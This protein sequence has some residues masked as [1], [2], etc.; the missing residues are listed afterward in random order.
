[1]IKR[2]K[3]NLY[4]IFVFIIFLMSLRIT[5]A[6]LD[7]SLLRPIEEFTTNNDELV[8]E[9][10]VICQEPDTVVVSVD[11][12]AGVPDLS[13]VDNPLN[14][15]VVDL[16]SSHSLTAMVLKPVFKD[17]LSLGPRVVNLSFS[18]DG[19]NFTDRGV[20][21]CTSGMGNEY[22]E[23]RVDFDAPINA[24]FVRIDII[25]GWQSGG[26]SIEEV[27]FLDTSERLFKTKTRSI[28]VV[29]R[30]DYEIDSYQASF[31]LTVLLKNG[32]NII[33][34]STKVLE[35]SEEDINEEIIIINANYIPHILVEEDYLILSDGYRAEV[36]IPPDALPSEI[37][38]VSINPLDVDEIIWNSYSDNTYIMRNTFPVMAYEILL[39]AAVPFPVD[40][41]DS[42][43]RQPPNLLVD[44]NYEYPSTWMTTTSALPIWIKI[45][46]RESHTLGRVIIYPRIAGDAA[47]GPKR[48]MILTS[49]DDE[50]YI[51]A[52]VCDDCN[53]SRIEIFLP[54]NPVARY[55]RLEIEEGWQGNNIQINELDFKDGEGA[56]IV[57]YVPLSGVSL[58][59]PVELTILYDD[60]DLTAAGIQ[61][62]ENLA[63]F[64]WNEGMDEWHLVGGRIDEANNWITVNLNHFSTLALFEK[65]ISVPEINWSYNPFSPNGDGIADNTTISISMGEESNGEAK[66]EIFDYTGKLIRTLMHEKSR[67]G[68]MSIVWDGKDE[69]GERVKIGPYIYQ[70]T[71]GK[72][73]RNGVLV[74]AR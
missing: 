72:E 8:I 3:I 64:T 7:L 57:S 27:A 15:L 67:S 70:V 35:P 43:E 26:V 29:L 46:L 59:R 68:Y 69:N 34:V 17:E 58:K 47:Y 48:L 30:I 52:A 40:A 24:R 28:S 31:K 62:E 45:D 42:L 60:K 13:L 38:K 16:G 33:A 23:A 36:S 2:K 54:N 61:R 39:S 4:L 5:Q 32:E 20:F 50:N 11:T 53:T 18:G 1:M 22:G 73:I 10:V 66:V 19:R 44:G 65:A 63:V 55:V 71:V 9:G 56:D 12:P 14:F 21:N 37:N 49:E 51:E 41:K 6:S 74:V 25:D